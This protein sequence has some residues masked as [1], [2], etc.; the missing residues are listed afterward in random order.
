VNR[1]H[2]LKKSAELLKKQHPETPVTSRGM[3]HVKGK[4]EMHAFWVT[5]GTCVAVGN[6]ASGLFAKDPAVK[7]ETKHA[8]ERIREET[9]L[10]LAEM[11]QVTSNPRNKMANKKEEPVKHQQQMKHEVGKIRDEMGP[12]LAEAGLVCKS[13]KDMNGK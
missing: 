1:I 8:V 11:G 7:Q 4:G 12:D 5:E 3:I 2:C 13:V 9:M 10:D 6:K